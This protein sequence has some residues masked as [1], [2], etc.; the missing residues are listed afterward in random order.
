M[1]KRKVIKRLLSISLHHYFT[2][3]LTLFSFDASNGFTGMQ[4]RIPTPNWCVCECAITA[5]LTEKRTHKN[6]WTKTGP[7]HVVRRYADN[8]FDIFI[9]NRMEKYS[10]YCTIFAGFWLAFYQKLLRHFTPIG[11]EVHGRHFSRFEACFKVLGID[12]HEKPGD[13]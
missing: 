9:T 6:W 10:N 11:E 13:E 4:Q 5:K 8:R 1:K 7:P 3:S 12:L 2:H